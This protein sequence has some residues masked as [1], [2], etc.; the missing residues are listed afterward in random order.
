LFALLSAAAT[1]L[2]F[3]TGILFFAVGGRFGKINDI[4]SVFQ[5]L[6]MVPLTI[7]FLRALPIH[8]PAI[9]VAVA[10]VGVLGMLT[11]AL[12]QTLL[13]FGRIDFQTSVK[14]F[15]AGAAIGAWLVAISILVVG[16]AS[17]P[18]PLAWIGI[19]AGIGYVVMVIGF[20]LGGQQ[21]VLFY[22]GSLAVG[23]GYPFWAIWLGRL[24]L[25]NAVGR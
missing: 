14:F 3:I 16:G 21:H 15:P 13:V 24:L 5:M 7:L 6:L 20:L 11:A 18:A 23:V 2:T 4:C 22:I 17:L 9:G 8:P 1:I 25:A 12:G 19:S 10:L